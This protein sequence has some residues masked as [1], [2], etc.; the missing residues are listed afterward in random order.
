MGG[1]VP[2]TFFD[3]IAGVSEFFIGKGCVKGEDVNVGSFFRNLRVLLHQGV[4]LALHKPFI[5]RCAK[6]KGSF[7]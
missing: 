4:A 1:N 5:S 7:S 6:D 3:I 2:D